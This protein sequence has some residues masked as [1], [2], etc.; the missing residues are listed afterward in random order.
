[1]AGAEA[2]VVDGAELAA[3]ARAAGF[4]LVGFARAEP[5]DPRVLLDWLEAGHH[6]DLDWLAERIDERLDV[7]RL[8]PGARTVMALAC[9]Y[10]SAAVPG[11]LVARYARGRDYHATLRD[12][13]R[14]LR[15][16]LRARWPGV[17]DYGSVD[18]NP[19]MEKVWAVRAGLG[20]VGKNACLITP[21][22][23]SWVVL[24]VM[25]LDV[26]VAWQQPSPFEVC[27]RCR[28][29]L[30]ACPTAA[31]VAD[32]VVDARA[33]LSYQ[34][35]ENDGAVP[36]PLREHLGQT[37]FGCDICQDVCPH[38]AREIPAGPRFAPRPI[39]SLTARALASLTPAQWDALA[40]GTPL[41]RPG[42][43]G[44]RRNAAYALGATRDQ[45]AR[46]LL[47]QLCADPSERVREAAGWAL[48]RLAGV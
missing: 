41:M 25:V 13:V 3:L 23:G 42:Y 31:I 8:L 47:E 29:C 11:S 27:G 36:E 33:C 39:A 22:F 26:D 4:D 12:R 21:R 1:V 37:V 10:S 19:V 16:A 28:L 34:T 20:A 30:D 6:A 40:P 32:R 15:R 18:A 44:V 14:T 43:D 2:R 38:N 5:I 45:G 24:A 9:N 46:A 35:I 48:E 7:K 17:H